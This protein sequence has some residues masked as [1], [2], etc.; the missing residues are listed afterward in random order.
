MTYPDAEL[1]QWIEDALLLDPR[2]AAQPIRVSANDGVVTLAGDVQ[3]QARKQIACAIA[4][5]HPA[6]RGVADHVRVVSP[7]DLSDEAIAENVRAA[8]A[9]LA[10]SVG[11]RTKVSVSHGVATLLGTVPTQWERAVAADVALAAAGVRSVDNK[12]CAGGAGL[13]RA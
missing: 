11:G 6:C 2:L 13:E 12:L 4:T 1:V 7:G 3:T 5:F 9:G 10:D 8:L